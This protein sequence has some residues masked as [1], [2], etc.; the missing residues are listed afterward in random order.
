MN[1]QSF[2]DALRAIEEHSDFSAMV[3][4]Y[5]DDSETLTPNDDK[6]HRGRSGAERFWHAYR[7]AFQEVRS[8]FHTVVERE[9]E[10]ILEWTS[11]GRNAHGAA[12]KYEGV[13]VVEFPDGRI[14]RFRAYFDPAA[15]LGNSMT[16]RRGFDSS[17]PSGRASSPS[18]A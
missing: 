1:A 12:I 10:A 17:S 4:L 13:S 3:S 11:Q 15:I 8:E 9:G 6:P 18:G 2:I 16:P 5:A 7:A 14:H